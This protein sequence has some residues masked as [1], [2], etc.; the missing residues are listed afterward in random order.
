MKFFHRDADL[1]HLVAPFLDSSWAVLD[2]GAGNGKLS[3][4]LGASTA[5]TMTLCDVYPRSVPGK[6]YL[7]MPSPTVLPSED[8]AY[9]AVMMLF[10]LHHM[11]TFEQQEQILREALRVARK[12]LVILEDTAV[13]RIEWLANRAFDYVLNAPH[14]VPTPF[15]FR[16]TNAW[17]KALERIGFHVWHIQTFRGTWQPTLK[18]YRQTLLV[19]EPRETRR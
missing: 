8:H 4:Q 16:S 3:S 14:G 17:H 1:V 9:D 5:A 10:M 11:A 18:T 19:A 12:R 6:T 7:S 13:G 15:T 2:V